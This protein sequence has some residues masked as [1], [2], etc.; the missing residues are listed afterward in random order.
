MII[1]FSMKVLFCGLKNEYGKPEAG[2]SFEYQNF[3]EVLNRMPGVEV[4]FFA[5]DELMR[6]HGRD[7]MNQQLLDRVKQEK[8]DLLFCF[9][10]SEELKK[11]V[12]K[13]ITEKTSTKTFNWFADDHWRFPIFSKYWAPVFTA[14]G[15]TDSTAVGKYKKLG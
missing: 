11:E 2:P 6:V 10:F 12:I 13:E 14:I 4:G 7:A 15:T 3:F 8:P 5:V 1:F 9:L